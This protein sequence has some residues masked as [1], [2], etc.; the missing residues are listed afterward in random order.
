MVP[1][2][3]VNYTPFDKKNH[4][5]AKNSGFSL[6]KKN[7]FLCPFYKPTP[8]AFSPT[9]SQNVLPSNCTKGPE[10]IRMARE[11]KKKRI[12]II[13]IIV[14]ISG[15]EAKKKLREGSK[16]NTKD[17][18]FKYFVGK[19]TMP[20]WKLTLVSSIRFSYLRGSHW[21]DVIPQR[22]MRRERQKE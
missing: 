20:V 4:L 13:I 22:L 14:D 18:I 16:I 1:F 6:V 15:L 17:K 7:I 5:E 2:K 3:S 8:E 11:S 21:F 10:S 9:F 12:I 19:Y